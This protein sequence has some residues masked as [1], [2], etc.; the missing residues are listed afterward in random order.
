MTKDR[1]PIAF[2]IRP[3]PEKAKVAEPA[4]KKIEARS[5]FPSREPDQEQH[6]QLNIRLEGHV[7]DRFR[8]AAKADRYSY[9]AFL[10]ILLDHYENSQ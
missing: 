7:S 5:Q 9:G 3:K 4:R 10:K 2:A 6:V 8:A 1:P